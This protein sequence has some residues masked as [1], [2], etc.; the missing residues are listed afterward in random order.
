MSLAI[1]LSMGLTAC[2]G[3]SSGNNSSNADD[4]AASLRLGLQVI[5]GHVEGAVCFG[6]VNRNGSRDAAESW[7]T[8]DASGKA[9]L[10]PTLVSNFLELHF[11]LENL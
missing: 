3:S 4:A 8:T 9:V 7:K 1:L 10:E 11:P 6:D 2:G 5:D